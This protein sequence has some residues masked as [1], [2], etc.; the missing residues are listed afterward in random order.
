MFRFIRK[1]VAKLNNVLNRP[2]EQTPDNIKYLEYEI[3]QWKR[4]ETRKM[5]IVGEEYYD[6]K[7]DILKRK[8][9][10]IGEGGK[11]KEVDNLPNNKV[12]DNQ[13]GKLVDQKVNYLLSKPFTYETEDKAYTGLLKNIFNKKFLRLFKNL[14]EDSLNGG[15]AWLHPYYSEKGELKFKR[16]EAREV[17]PFWKD[18][19]HTELDFAVRLYVTEEFTGS[20][21]ET[22][23]KVEVYTTDGVK[24]YILR[25][26]YLIEDSINPHSSFITIEDTTSGE[27]QEVNW[28]RV[29]LIAFKYNNNETPLIKRVKSL[30]DGIN[31]M[32]S[33]FENN[34]QE[35][36]RNTIL[37]LVNYDGQNLGEFRRNLSEY[38]AVKVKTVDGAAGDIKTLEIKVNAD[39]Y[40]AIIELFK[41]AIIENGRGYDAKSDKVGN[42]PNQ[43][44]IQSMYSDI[45]LDT[46]GMET[47]YQ[48]SFEDLIWFIDNHLS[49]TGEGDFFDKEVNIKFNRKILINESEMI[50]NCQ[51][52]T[53]IISSKTI[54]SRHPW[55][56]DVA[57]ER[58]RL[59]GE[60]KKAIEDYMNEDLPDDTG[61]GV[62]EE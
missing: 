41:K 3:N 13:Y 17:L 54:T 26:N 11:L 20:R 23:E 5:Q 37:V 39:N 44:N 61:G 46:D 52:S 51:K 8:R 6:D 53:G 42:N 35:D 15:I 21:K 9:T 7:H 16:F 62:G 47:E 38:G 22:V 55:V 31:T 36:A 49:N 33:D 4:S 19:E 48:A 10:A 59:E 40:K 43:M 34:M 25:N 50:D 14:G 28:E 2:Q 57:K 12:I 32:L 18:G 1:G 56:D 29:P 58:K 60:K 24:R 30:Q 27:Q 45:E